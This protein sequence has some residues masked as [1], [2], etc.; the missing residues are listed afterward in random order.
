MYTLQV[1]WIKPP[2]KQ[3]PFSYPQ[4]QFPNTWS[5]KHSIGF[6]P[7]AKDG[8]RMHYMRLFEFKASPVQ[9]HFFM[10]NLISCCRDPESQTNFGGFNW[11][12]IPRK[13][14]IIAIAELSSPTREICK[15]L[16][17]H[18]MMRQ[19]EVRLGEDPE[20]EIGQAQRFFQINVCFVK[21]QS[22]SQTRRPERS[23]TVCRNFAPM[24]R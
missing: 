9:R 15:S 23:Y 19:L 22:T 13:S 3:L 11:K 24:R 21:S 1:C 4:P 14:H 2:Q 10:D 17:N 16:T 8:G 5:H 12:R 18:L 20:T 6:P 7:G